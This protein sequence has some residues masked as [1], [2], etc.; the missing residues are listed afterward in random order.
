M[1]VSLPLSGG[2]LHTPAM[3]TLRSCRPCPPTPHGAQGPV[4]TSLLRPLRAQPKEQTP[5]PL[6]HCSL[7]EWELAHVNRTQVKGTSQVTEINPHPD[8]CFS[9]SR[10]SWVPAWAP[11]PP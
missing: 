6:L 2:L 1:R 3:L 7:Q 8:H 11:Q 4:W 9:A 5:P 10:Q